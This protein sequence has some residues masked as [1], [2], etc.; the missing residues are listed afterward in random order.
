MFFTLTELEHHPILFDVCY[1]PGEIQFPEEFSQ[2]GDLRVAGTAELLRNTLGEIRLRGHVTA[3][4]EAAC[5]RCLE[6][7]R[8]PVDG[9]FDLFYRPAVK[10]GGHGEV[11]LE[12]GEIDLS[13]YDGDGVEL[14][15]AIREHVLLSLPMQAICRE[16]CKGLCP[17]CGVNRNDRQCGCATV[18]SDARWEAFKQ[19]R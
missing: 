3:G 19:L 12:E 5:D 2:I 16:D 9:D 4:I 11:H 7:A 18:T 13:F 17:V 8:M 1:R 14:R 6:P 15:E 10:A